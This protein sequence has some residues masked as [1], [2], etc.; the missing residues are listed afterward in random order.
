MHLRKGDLRFEV[1]L[2]IERYTVAEVAQIACTTLRVATR[3]TLPF[4]T[5]AILRA[6]QFDDGL[7][8]LDR[9]DE[10]AVHFTPGLPPPAM[11]MFVRNR[12]A[13]VPIVLSE[14]NLK[15]N[16]MRSWLVMPLDAGYCLVPE[17]AAS[18]DQNDP[19]DPTHPTGAMDPDNRA[20][21]GPE[22]E[23]SP[24]THAQ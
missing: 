20:G 14:E 1:R 18:A 13:G 21:S 22:P 7:Y 23:H 15:A 12:R 19:M 11:E 2:S 4:R 9:D 24:D 5:E 16:T 8:L 3:E 6:Q 10:T 17:D